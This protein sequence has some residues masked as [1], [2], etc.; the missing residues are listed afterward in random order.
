MRE[1]V[2]PLY[3]ERLEGR[4]SRAQLEADIDGALR[5][6]MDLKINEGEKVNLEFSDDF[7]HHYIHELGQREAE[8]VDE[9]LWTTGAYP[10]VENMRNIILKELKTAGFDVS[11]G[12]RIEISLHT[13][14]E[15][16]KAA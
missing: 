1:N 14:A 9:G 2:T 7:G 3:P 5:D 10:G 15:E 6:G 8:N 11:G 13:K 4:Y 16:R 12:R